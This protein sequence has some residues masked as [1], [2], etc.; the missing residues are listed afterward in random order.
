MR[1]RP[2]IWIPTVVIGV[3]LFLLPTQVR[4][5]S[6]EHS[7]CPTVIPTHYEMTY[8]PDFDHEAL[9]GS[10]RL[11]YRNTGEQPVS[12]LPFSLYRL[13]DVTAVTDNG[14]KPLSYE[15]S[16][17]S[18]A[19]M[20]R[21]QVN[22]VKVKLPQPLAAGDTTTI[23]IDFEGYLLGY[24][25]TGMRYI[26]DH[27]DPEFTI[28]RLD[29]EAYPA[30]TCPD[31]ADVFGDI[32]RQ[33]FTYTVSV[34]VPQGLVVANGGK[35]MG[36][37]KKDGKAVYTYSSI[38]P[39][40]RMDFAI[41]PYEELED[42]NNRIFCFREDRNGAVSM[43]ST[44]K[45]TMK[46]YRKWFGPLQTE[47]ALT[48]IEIPD[49]WGSQT[50]VTTIIQ[51][52]PAFQRPEFLYELY[53]ELAHRWAV[54]ELEQYPDRFEAEGIAMF[55]QDLLRERL[56]GTGN[57]VEEGVHQSNLR[58]KKYY[59]RY[60]N[61][62]NLPLNKL[63]EADATRLA[64]SKGMVFFAALYKL[65][66]EDQFMHVCRSFYETY[67]QTGAT[68]DQFV[69]HWKTHLHASWDVDRFFNDWVYS[70]ESSDMMLADW[71]LQQIVEHYGHS[72]NNP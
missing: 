16:V 3:T 43:L 9:Y 31:V 1:K 22:Y 50:D 26:K 42:G 12:T 11:T 61:L 40:W 63:G 29:G 10:C 51:T 20:F 34:E 4:S 72:E 56:Q 38:S 62:K 27:I 18:T 57:A 71:N 41:A 35:L 33:Q 32:I 23:A 70:A 14:G 25:E 7:N 69:S 59:E 53:H 58:F 39:S 8:R 46:L 47:T 5:E 17:I 2:T 21:K 37:E 45:N 24:T 28:L 67:V 66:G 49:M 15:E 68:T 64:Y 30:V 65:A 13:L 52:A 54:K 60:P 19:R 44:M 48:V 6:A 55:L 36:I